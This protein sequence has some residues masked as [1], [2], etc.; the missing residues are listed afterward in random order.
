MLRATTRLPMVEC[1]RCAN[2]RGGYC[3]KFILFEHQSTGRLQFLIGQCCG[4]CGMLRQCLQMLD[5][6]IAPISGVFPGADNIKAGH[7]N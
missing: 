4:P 6:E 3:R 1:R 7:G 5:R 2:D